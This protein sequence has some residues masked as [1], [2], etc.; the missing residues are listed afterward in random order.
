[1]FEETTMPDNN[2]DDG[3]NASRGIVLGTLVALIAYL[4]IFL[5]AMSH[6]ERL[7]R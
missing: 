6:V 5:A 3:L 1:M 2:D 4:L 7:L